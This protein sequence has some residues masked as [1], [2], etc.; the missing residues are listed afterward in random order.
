M[1]VKGT[2]HKTWEHLKDQNWCLLWEEREEGER[3]TNASS[4]RKLSFQQFWTKWGGRMKTLDW[5]PLDLRMIRAMILL[6]IGGLG[7]EVC[8]EWYSVTGT[9]VV[10]QAVW[11]IWRLRCIFFLL[12][13]SPCSSQFLDCYVPVIYHHIQFPQDWLKL[14]PMF[15][16]ATI[17]LDFQRCQECLQGTSPAFFAYH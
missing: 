10:Q 16:L 5:S 2:F 4:F 11:G 8:G 13:L 7:F 6:L 9:V 15:P 1:G 12:F 14:V 3:Q 17:P